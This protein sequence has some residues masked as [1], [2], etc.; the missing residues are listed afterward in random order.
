MNPHF[1]TKQHVRPEWVDYNGHMN[2]AEYAKAFSIAAEDFI[3]YIGLDEKG[4]SEHAYTIFTL[5]T[6]ICYLKEAHQGEELTIRSQILDKDVKRIHQFLL[7]ENNEGELVA[8]MEQMLMGM[9]RKEG[10]PK[11]FPEV[12]AKKIDEIFNEDAKIDKPKQVGR[13]IGIK[14]K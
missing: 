1:S 11:P 3:D 8:T 10:K 5:E 12:V 6:H 14:R 2:D 9:D 13:I 4:R 7:M